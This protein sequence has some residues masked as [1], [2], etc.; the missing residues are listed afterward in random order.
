MLLKIRKEYLVFGELTIFLLSTVVGYAAE[1][2]GAE[3]LERIKGKAAVT[4]SGQATVNLIT[5][6]KRGEQRE[7]KVKIYRK[8]ME[9][10]EKQL[11]EYLE[12]ADVEG[13]KF[14][15]ITEEAKEDLMYLYLPFLG[16]ERRIAAQEKTKTFMGT[17]F[18]Y[19]EIGSSESYREKYTAKRLEDEIFEDYPCYVLRLSPKEKETKYSYLKMWVWKD[20]FLPLKIEFYGKD[21]KLEKVLTDSD[22]RKEKEDYIPYK[23]V[24]ADQMKGTRTIIEILET[25]EEEV[26]EDYFTLRYLRR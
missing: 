26:S 18:T 2:T 4:R 12:P 19:E 8:V 9:K 1:L 16:R 20:K 14:L 5:V 21:E 17:D 22:L 15:S 13:T 6:N 3:I 11:I 10:V 7:N 25:K 23:I 24:M